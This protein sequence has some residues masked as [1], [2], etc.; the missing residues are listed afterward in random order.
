MCIVDLGHNATHVVPVLGDTI[1]WAA[2]RRHI[3]SQRLLTNL[4]KETLSFR[5][6][7]MMDEAWLVGHIK[8]R[9]CFV[10]NSAGRR[11][12]VSNSS[13]ASEWSYAAMMEMCAKMPR[14][15]NCLAVEYVLPDYSYSSAKDKLG[16]VRGRKEVKWNAV[17]LDSFIVGPSLDAEAK[18]TERDS[19]GEGETDDDKD[20]ESDDDFREGPSDLPAQPKKKAKTTAAAA[21]KKDSEVDQVLFLEKERFQVPE[22]MFDPSIIGTSCPHRL[23]TIC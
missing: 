16:H 17:D 19:G 14:H 2:V 8:E 12:E 6:W 4:L 7:D 1:V 23:K 18:A 3:V 11:G 22:V 21:E 10:A 9:C 5:Q 13:R 20:D 15:R